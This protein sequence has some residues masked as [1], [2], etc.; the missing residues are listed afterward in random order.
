[1]ASQAQRVGGLLGGVPRFFAVSGRC[2]D[3]SRNVV[4][5]IHCLLVAA[6]NQVTVDVHRHLNRMVSHLFLDVGQGFALL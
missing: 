5:S 4:E 1:M 6:G 3:Q 2:G